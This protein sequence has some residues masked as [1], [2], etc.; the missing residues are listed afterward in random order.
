LYL[1]RRR[2]DRRKLEA[3]IAA[4]AAAEQRERELVIEQLLRSVS[5]EPHSDGSDSAR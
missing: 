5:A 1:I 4:D 2:R 3:M